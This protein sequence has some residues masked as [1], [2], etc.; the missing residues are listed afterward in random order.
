VGCFARVKD[1]RHY[2]SVKGNLT[3]PI[4]DP[5]GT[6]QVLCASSPSLFEGA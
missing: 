4:S 5:L 2:Y 1:P 6:K 3:I